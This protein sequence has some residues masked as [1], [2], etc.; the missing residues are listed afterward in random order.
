MPYY[1]ALGLASL[2]HDITLLTTS[3]KETE[4]VQNLRDSKVKIVDLKV[5]NK[6]Y[7]IAPGDNWGRW[8][9]ESLEFVKLARP[10]I[11]TSNFDLLVT[12][13]TVDAI[14]G[15][16]TSK[17][18]VLHL[19]GEAKTV[20]FAARIGLKNS[21]YFI[22]HSQNIKLYWSSIYCQLRS[23]C[24][25]VYNGVDIEKY[26]HDSLKDIDI[27]FIGRLIANK[28]VD[29]MIMALKL[30]SIQQYKFKTV[31]VGSG[32]QE[33]FLKRMV[34][35]YGLTEHVSFL[36]STSE[37]RKVE[38][39]GRARLFIAP[40]WEREA[41]LLTALEAAASKVPIIATRAGGIEEF[42]EDDV[43]A[44]L[45]TPGDAPGIATEILNILMNAHTSER[46]IRGAFKRVQTWDWKNRVSEI[47]SL[48]FRIY[49]E[50]CNNF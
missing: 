44:R 17:C 29:V 4:Y 45:V 24:E 37:E 50:F 16:Y 9:S 14:I 11:H 2:G 42:L 28:G 41:V 23:S 30:L 35:D 36:G 47:E 1:H 25:V 19:H 40:S 22:A 12:H 31:I 26:R 6:V 8:D 7:S 48:Y 34:K 49:E 15:A 10:I 13:N 27:I 32:P 5:P 33:E 46:L 39:L 3:G 18:S 20:N 38:L 21:D 43:S